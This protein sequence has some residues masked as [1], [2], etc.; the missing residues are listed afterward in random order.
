MNNKQTYS[1][2]RKFRELSVNEV[3]IMDYLMQKDDIVEITYSKLTE[4]LGLNKEKVCTNIRKAMLH[5]QELGL[6]SIINKYGENE[7]KAKCNPMIACFI[8]DNWMDNLLS[9]ND[10]VKRS[11]KN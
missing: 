5:L 1:L 9:R 3:R 8:D 4:E 7:S 11:C 2:M 6:V 10:V